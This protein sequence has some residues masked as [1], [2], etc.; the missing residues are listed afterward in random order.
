MAL[1]GD[2]R[3]PDEVEAVQQAGG[4]VIRLT[5]SLHEDS[6]VSE[7]ALDTHEGFDA[8]IDNQDMTIEEQSKALLNTLGEWGWLESV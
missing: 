6:H 5:R 3:F 2:C 4:K 8:V 7:T 1:V